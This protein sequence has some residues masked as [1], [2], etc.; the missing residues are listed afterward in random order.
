MKVS[1]ILPVYNEEEYV[2]KCLTSLQTQS[3]P[4]DEI[5]VVDNNSRDRTVEIAKKFNARIIREK[6]QGI[7]YARNRGFD[8][9]KG[10]ILARID[11]DSILPKNWIK[12]IKYNFSRY[13]IDGLTGPV[14]FYDFPFR[15]PAYAQMYLEIFKLVQKGNNT[16][17]GPNMAITKNIWK[18]VRNK[19]CMDNT[20]VHEDIDLA[21]H[22]FQAG[23]VIKRDDTLIANCSARRLLKHPKQFFTEY[24]VRTV[25]T[26]MIHQPNSFR[27]F[28]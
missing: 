12:R 27:S 28:I 22:I 17:I 24:P 25:N 19:V 9:A 7:S 20:K 13:K 15:T 1:V 21:I 4:P 10:D 11:A 26:V 3:V 23:G 6:K 5:L 18:K 8:E 16:L 2:K 14:I